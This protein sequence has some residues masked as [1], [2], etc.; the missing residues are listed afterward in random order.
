D[1]GP[2]RDP[3]RWHHRR[4]RRGV[5]DRRDHPARGRAAA[6]GVDPRVGVPRPARRVPR[7]VGRRDD[8]V[9]APF[10][11]WWH[12]AYGLDVKILRPPHVVLTLGIVAVA[13]GGVMLVLATQNRASGAPRRRLEGLI[14]LLGGEVLVLAMISI[15]EHTMRANLH[16]ADAYRA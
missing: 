10:D 1:A 16:R 14:L 11:N 6:G 4:R 8:G 7:G 5:A 3:A 9:S 15:M 13:A 12:N 2:R